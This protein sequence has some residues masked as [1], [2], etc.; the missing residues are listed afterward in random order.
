MNAQF[1]PLSAVWGEAGL[2]CPASC[3]HSERRGPHTN[4]NAHQSTIPTGNES[5][6]KGSGVCVE[7]VLHQHRVRLAFKV[8]V[9][10]TGDPIQR[11]LNP[12]VRPLFTGGFQS[13][14]SPRE[15]LNKLGL[16]SCVGVV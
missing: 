10:E 3:A 2:S 1:R 5:S 8:H 13:R 14:V 4:P 11:P 15:T 7:P 16:G 6:E 12:P 9:F